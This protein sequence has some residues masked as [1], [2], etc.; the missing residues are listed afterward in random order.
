MKLKTFLTLTLLALLFAG[1]AKRSEIEDLQSQIDNLKSEKI[2]S[3]EG[4]I[5][6]IQ[7]S[8]LNLQSTDKELQTYISA[9]QKQASDLEKTD[10]ELEAAIAKLKTELSGE[11]SEVEANCLAQLD[12]YKTLVSS[13]LASIY[14]SIETLQE[15]DKEM[16]IKEQN[17]IL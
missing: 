14:A 15:K 4:Q 1:C 7:T 2:N 12:A 16:L 10:K 6:A 8:I 5:T 17:F 9:L 13:Q 11:I 3:I